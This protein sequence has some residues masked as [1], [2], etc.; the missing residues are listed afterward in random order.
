MV[1]DD[2]EKAAK[3]SRAIISDIALYNGDRIAHAMDPERDLATEIEEGRR[4][5]QSRVTPRFYMIFEDAVRGWAADARARATPAV[6]VAR[7]TAGRDP[8][9]A[10]QE[11][12]NAETLEAAKRTRTVTLLMVVLLVAVAGAT[13]AFVSHERDHDAHGKHEGH[14]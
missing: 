10:S 4:L 13:F 7:E 1:I 3:L 2:A 5:F 12:R 14:R 9:L 6:V 11:R 8:V